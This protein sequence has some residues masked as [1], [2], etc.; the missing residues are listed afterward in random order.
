[1]M[2]E[3]CVEGHTESMGKE[4]DV[5]RKCAA[6]QPVATFIKDNPVMQDLYACSIF[7]W[8]ADLQT[9]TASEAYKVGQEIASLRKIVFQALPGQLQ[10]RIMSGQTNKAIEHD[11]TKPN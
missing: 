10:K 7:E 4:G 9:E 6:W 3:V 8:A 2:K 11:G 1:M 5:P